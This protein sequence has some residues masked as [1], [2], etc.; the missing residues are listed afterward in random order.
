M[1]L[2]S[3]TVGNAMVVRLEGNLD[4]NSSTEVQDYLNCSMDGGAAN[5][6]VNL[7][8]VDFVSSNGLRTLLATAKRLSAS[9]G[10]L[11]ICG[12]N[13]TVAEVFEI[14][15]FSTILDVYPSEVE[16]LSAHAGGASGRRGENEV[17]L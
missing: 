8:D 12:L 6:V 14:S 13:E 3:E 16:A 17:L 11:R 1:Q 7:A 4:T 2:S 15:G 9:G 10:C 5:I